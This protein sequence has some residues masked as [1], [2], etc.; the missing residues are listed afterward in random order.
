M[1]GVDMCQCGRFGGQGDFGGTNDRQCDVH[2]LHRRDHQLI[3]LCRGL[4]ERCLTISRPSQA[5]RDSSASV[6]VL[7]KRCSRV[8]PGTSQKLYLTHQS[9]S[10]AVSEDFSKE[11]R[12]RSPPEIR[13]I[14]PAPCVQREFSNYDQNTR[15]CHRDTHSQAIHYPPG[16][17][18][19]Q[20][21]PAEYGH[22]PKSDCRQ[23]GYSKATPLEDRP[24]STPRYA[25]SWRSAFGDTEVA[26]HDV[27]R[28][29]HA[30]PT[31]TTRATS[32]PPRRSFPMV[33][34]PM[35]LLGR[36]CAGWWYDSM[37]GTGRRRRGARLNGVSGSAKKSVV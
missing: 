24:C 12:T 2:R 18:A 34:M 5:L 28:M 31:V 9:T 22:R 6:A 10:Q 7:R 15:R 3:I 23:K 29:L 11:A 17:R 32:P 33:S 20:L 19:V 21:P 14:A 8:S 37:A 25:R 36:S 1:P 26:G 16:P 35:L 27:R 13:W 4:R 30:M